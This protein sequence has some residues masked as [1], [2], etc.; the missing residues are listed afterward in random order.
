MVQPKAD[1]WMCTE[2]ESYSVQP[3]LRQTHVVRM[4]KAIH[5]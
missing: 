5:Q 1:A 2:A 3:Q 4:F